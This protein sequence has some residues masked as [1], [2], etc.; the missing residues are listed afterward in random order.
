MD[1]VSY[2]QRFSLAGKNAVVTGAVGI[3]GRPFCDGLAEF[4]ANVAVVDLDEATCCEV[5]TELSARHGVKAI[6]IGCD[7]TSAEAVE[8]MVQRAVAG[9]GDIHVLH[10]NVG[11]KTPDLDAY[12]ASFESYSLD[13]WR[14]VM[15]VNIDGVFLVDQAVGR[16]MVKQASG[17]SVVHTASIYGAMA[18]DQRIYEGSEYLGRAINTPAVYSA[19]KAAVIGLTRYLATYWAEQGIRVNCITP[20]GA[21]S[22]QND[23]FKQRYSARIPLGRMAQREEMVNA[24]IYLASDASSYVTG[25]NIMVDGG[26]SA[27]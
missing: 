2:K 17:G 19:S 22:G 4:G 25:Q 1:D 7:I 24:L 21:E 8:N 23:N 9:L 10:N 14:R 11:G 15:A 12:F 3:L 18:P 20:G 26:L 27:W 5:A 6:G 16:R 13:E